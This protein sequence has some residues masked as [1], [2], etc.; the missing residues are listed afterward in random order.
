MIIASSV[1][2]LLVAF[3]EGFSTAS[4]ASSSNAASPPVKEIQTF[5]ESP[6]KGSLDPVMAE[7]ANLGRQISRLQ[8]QIADLNQS[9]FDSGER[10]QKIYLKVAELR[11]SG[12]GRMVKQ[13]ELEL[14]ASRLEAEAMALDKKIGESHS[15]TLQ[16][17]RSEMAEKS[18]AFRLRASQARGQSSTLA[19]ENSEAQMKIDRM[20]SDAHRESIS[21]A[22]VRVQIVEFERKILQLEQKMQDLTNQSNL[23]LSQ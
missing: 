8:K 10:S 20:Y 12:A 4:H 13:A 21:A 22:K 5:S 6:R 9:S 17:L 15:K 1:L 16:K 19:I 18:A 11:F 14:E 3:L 2:I 23:K 7:I